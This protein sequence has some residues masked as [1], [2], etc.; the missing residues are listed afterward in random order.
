M[1]LGERGLRSAQAEEAAQQRTIEQENER[2]QDQ[3]RRR[4]L[5]TQTQQN[6]RVAES[7]ER[8]YEDAERAYKARKASLEHQ[9]VS[10]Q[11]S[12]NRLRRY[13]QHESEL[14]GYV[15]QID[16]NNDEL[17]NLKVPLR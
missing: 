11:A 10:L 3:Q 12:I 17:R 15:K 4:S 8:N 14:N 13:G 16:A 5:A 9:N 7:R 1:V 6:I 2:Q